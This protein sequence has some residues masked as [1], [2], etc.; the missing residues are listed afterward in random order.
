MK[1]YLECPE[2]FEFFPSVC[3]AYKLEPGFDRALNIFICYSRQNK[4]TIK[5]IR[6]QLSNLEG[7]YPLRIWYDNEIAPGEKWDNTIRQRLEISDIFIL[8]ICADF[9]VSQYIIEVELEEAMKKHAERS[10]TII[11]IITKPCNWKVNKELSSLQALPENG[12]AITLHEDRD[13]AYL[14]VIEGV[15]RT[16]KK[17]YQQAK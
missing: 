1:F 4:D 15:E 2:L 9:L 17:I 13:S 8:L 3:K 11:P 16:I 14:E 6:K 10:A 7:S 5:E 12:R